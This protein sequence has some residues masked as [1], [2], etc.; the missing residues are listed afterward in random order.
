MKKDIRV[1]HIMTMELVVGNVNNKFSQVLDFFCKFKIAHLPIVEENNKLLGIIS[2]NDAL[3]YMHEKLGVGSSLNRESLDAEFKMDELM[4][5]E[6]YFIAADATV[7]EALERLDKGKFQALPVV[8]NEIIVGIITNKDLVKA[9]SYEVN[10]VET[11][12]TYSI[13]TSGFGI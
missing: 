2:V 5:P 10:P 1:K 7:E 12:S 8:E 6:P 11:R 3:N 9:F 13:E 4:T